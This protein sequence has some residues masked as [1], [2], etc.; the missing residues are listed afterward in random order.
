MPASA[1]KE[2]DLLNREGSFSEEGLLGLKKMA[3]VSPPNSSNITCLLRCPGHA[4]R[5]QRL[6]FLLNTEEGVLSNVGSSQPQQQRRHPQQGL[7]REARSVS[8]RLPIH[9]ARAPIPSGPLRSSRLSRSFVF[10]AARAP[11]FSVCLSTYP[12]NGFCPF[13]LAEPKSSPDGRGR[14]E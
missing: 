13:C 11:C 9:L 5:P 3:L 10:V 14:G 7:G 8:A 2:S 4:I 1:L 6:R 12:K